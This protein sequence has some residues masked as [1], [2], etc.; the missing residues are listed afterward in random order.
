MLKRNPRGKIALAVLWGENADLM[1]YSGFLSSPP[2]RVSLK[3]YV[4]CCFFLVCLF[5]GCAAEGCW[6]RIGRRCDSEGEQRERLAGN[7]SKCR[8]AQ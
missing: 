4:R 1:T 7:K 2:A 6:N 8:R 3:R 5:A